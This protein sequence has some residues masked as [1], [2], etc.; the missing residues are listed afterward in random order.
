MHRRGNKTIKYFGEKTHPDWKTRIRR[1]SRTSWRNP[2]EPQEETERFLFQNSILFHSW[3]FF[4]HVGPHPQ[5]LKSH[6]SKR[7]AINPKAVYRTLSFVTAGWLPGSDGGT[8]C[9]QSVVMSVC[10]TRGSSLEPASAKWRKALDG[11]KHQQKCNF[12]VT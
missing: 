9:Q 7:K 8:L 12:C 5:E 4:V 2:L 1:T 10:G 6:K 3:F 11:R